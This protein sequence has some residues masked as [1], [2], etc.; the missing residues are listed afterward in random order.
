MAK[1]QTRSDDLTLIRAERLSAGYGSNL[2]IR[3]IDLEIRRGE[4]VAL[5]G[6]NGAGKTTT[7]LTLGGELRAAT[8]RVVWNNSGKWEPL[9]RRARQGF[10]FVPEDGAVFGGLTAH[11]NLMVARRAERDS[12]MHVFPELRDLL[13]RRGGLLSGGEQ[14]ML[15]VG[16]AIGGPTRLL[17]ADELSL[18]L[19]PRTVGV[20]LKAIRAAAE[21][22]LG[23]L[24]VEQHVHRALGFVDRV[25]VMQRGRIT[26]DMTAAEAR[27]NIDE[28]QAQ[29]LTA[30]APA[31]ITANGNN[32]EPTEGGGA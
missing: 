22:G 19:A 4:V 10:A 32:V 7:L 15:A 2:A 8:G 21:R 6:P 11:Q 31:G 13:H 18:G 23:A 1:P 27:K 16:R 9:H 29:Y 17:V 24:I 14:R 28:I 3:D 20:I 30:E 25:Y 5:F 26:L 12:A